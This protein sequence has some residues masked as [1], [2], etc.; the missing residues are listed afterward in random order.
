MTGLGRHFNG[1]VGWLARNRWG[2]GLLPLALVLAMGASSDRVKTYFW[3]SDLHEP[4][5]T[6]QGEWRSYSEP[7]TLDDGEHTMSLKAR[8]DSVAPLTAQQAA[9]PYSYELP[10]GTTA[11]QVEL[12]IQADPG[13]P[14]TGCSMALRD[15]DGNQYTYQATDVA[16]GQ[17]TSSC[18]PADTPGP[19]TA[20][21]QLSE[22]DPDQKPRPA[23]YTVKPIW[24][25]PAG[26]KITEVDLWWTIPKYVAF[27]AVT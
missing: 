21:G 5:V 2:L 23:Q 24:V 16:G 13:T 15:G 3:D 14:L 11:V 26:V 9:G 18:V 20:L 6:A 10:D 27:R 1:Q 25:I 7:Y 17:P 12:S 19:N 22:P 4:L 8:L